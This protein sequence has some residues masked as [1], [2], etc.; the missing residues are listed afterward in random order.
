MPSQSAAR[1]QRAAVHPG[2]AG[3]HGL[4][5]AVHLH[6]RLLH[7]CE[8]AYLQAG[9]GAWERK[10]LLCTACRPLCTNNGCYFCRP[11]GPLHKVHSQ[12]PPGHAG[13]IA[14][15]APPDAHWVPSSLHTQVREIRLVRREGRS[16][17]CLVLLRFDA[18]ASA[19]G[20][21]RDFNGR[22]VG[23]PCLVAQ[24]RCALA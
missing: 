23:C 10:R 19:D 16:S 8:F 17:V 4:C 1:A 11:A 7:A 21:Y 18:Q 3:G 22:P 2:A 9:W 15:C 6:G 24:C 13:T 5:G 20:F 14:R 12:P